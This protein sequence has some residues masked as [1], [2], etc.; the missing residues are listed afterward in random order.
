MNGGLGCV[1]GAPVERA[2]LRYLQEVV[3]SLLNGLKDVHMVR[4][5][6]NAHPFCILVHTHCTPIFSYAYM[7]SVRKYYTHRTLLL[8]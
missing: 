8:F 7:Y 1:D 3:L 4:F 6:S 5:L 2:L